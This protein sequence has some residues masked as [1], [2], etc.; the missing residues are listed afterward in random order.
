MRLTT[1]NLPFDSAQGK[2]TDNSQQSTNITDCC[3]NSGK[4]DLD[5]GNP[6]ICMLASCSITL[7]DRSVSYF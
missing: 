5:S 2:A 1:D 7:A 6:L 4:S 3:K